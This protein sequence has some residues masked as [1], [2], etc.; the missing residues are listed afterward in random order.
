M[1][2]LFIFLKAE[3]ADRRYIVV[4]IVKMIEQVIVTGD[5]TDE[6]AQLHF[7]PVD[8]EFM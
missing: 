5:R 1:V 7:G 4:Y 2:E 6:S 3:A 8:D